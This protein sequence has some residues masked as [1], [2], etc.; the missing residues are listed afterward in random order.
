MAMPTPIAPVGDWILRT[1]ALREARAR[2]GGS[3]EEYR[4]AVDQVKM[5]AEV[6]RRVAEPVEALPRGS[7]PAV[8]LAL[9]RDAVY[10]ALVADQARKAGAAGAPDLAALWAASD[11]TLL[12]KAAG[13]EARLNL[14]RGALLERPTGES[15]KATEDEV[16]AARLFVENLL[17]ELDAPA[18]TIERLQVQRWTRLTA[19]VVVLVGAVIGVRAALRGPNLVGARVFKT[20]TSLPECTAPNRCVDVFFH[21]QPQNEP[22]IDFDLGSVKTVSRVEV[23]NRTDCCADRAVPLIVEV[24]LDDKTWKQVARRDTEF[25]DWK[26]T[27]PKEKARHVRLRVPRSSTLHLEDVVV[28]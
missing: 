19:I 4:R 25:T 15:L 18:R 7:R 9:Y 26:A 14:L 11:Q 23:R 22:W 16:A 10:W 2:A 5:L 13:E 20:S 8:L 27:F 1:R 28:R 24:S 21:T 3:S 6:A 12:Q 17:W